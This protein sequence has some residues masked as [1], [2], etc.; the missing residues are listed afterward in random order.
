MFV[1]MKRR[2]YRVIKGL[3]N[4]KITS[5]GLIYKNWEDCGGVSDS[6]KN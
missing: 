5:I 6:V 1:L 3:S 2:Y 4:N